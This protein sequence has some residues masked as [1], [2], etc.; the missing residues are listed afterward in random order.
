TDCSGNTTTHTQTITIED[1]APPTFAE[2]LPTDLTVSCGQIPEAEVLTAI[3]NCDYSASDHF[4]EMDTTVSVTFN[5]MVTSDGCSNSIERIWTATDCSG[6]TTTH[7]QTITIED[8]EAPA[9][10]AASLELFQEE[11]TT[12]C[13]NIP[14]TPELAFQDQCSEDLKVNF[15]ETSTYVDD[16]TDYEIQR[17]W[18]VTDPCNNQ[19]TFTQTVKVNQHN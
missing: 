5:E 3:D 9:L 19:S 12:S 1:K 13:A 15:E 17:V 18:Q 11:I 16:Q 14:A 6:N 7:T 2:T 4:K 8:K 10:T